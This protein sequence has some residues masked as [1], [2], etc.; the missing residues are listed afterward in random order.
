MKITSKP[1]ALGVLISFL[2][3]I[4]FAEIMGWWQTE[5][6]KV[7][8]TFTEGEAAGEYNPADIRGSYTLGDISDLS[9]LPLEDL[10]VAFRVPA[11]EAA[12]FAL[13]SL[14]TLYAEAEYEIGTASVRLF[15]AWYKGLPYEISEDAYLPIEAAQ[16][17]SAKA[18][19]DAEQ[20]AYLDTHSIL[21][22]GSLLGTAAPETAPADSA[23]VKQTL[24][25][26]TTEV[27]STP[28]AAETEHVAPDRT[29]TGQTTFQN[30]LD[31]GLSRET[32]EQI[33]GFAMPATP[34]TLLKDAVS[35]QGSSFSTV[36]TSLQAELDK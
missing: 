3:G 1:L 21:P 32:I 13:K 7:P 31:W 27:A 10:A 16:I 8:A 34:G 35:A 24:P 4:F 26:P 19:L 12:A 6:T 15:V 5:T 29:I 11:D 18:S 23:E 20:T 17:L 14:E 9:A 33:C 22:D 30:L 2:G 25:S 28:V 36:K